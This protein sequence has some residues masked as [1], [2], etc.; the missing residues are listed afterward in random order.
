MPGAEVVSRHWTADTEVEDLSDIDIGL[1]PLPDEPWALGKCGL[2]ALRYMGLG[3]PAV[4]SPV[5]VNTE[6]V[7]HGENGLVAN[8]DALWVDHLK[9]LIHDSGLR[10]RLGAE[11]RKTVET[12]YSARIVAPKVAEI[13]RQ[14]T[15]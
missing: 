5:G 6:I 10:R 7:A 3:I 15:A 14:A 1:M 2:K 4:V 8:S 13:F 11:A 9:T 12:R